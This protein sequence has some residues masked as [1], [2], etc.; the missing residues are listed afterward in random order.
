MPFREAFLAAIEKSNLKAADK[1]RLREVADDNEKFR[2]VQSAATAHAKLRGKAG[3][4]GAVDWSKIIDLIVQL[5][6]VILK[7]FGM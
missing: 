7:L 3:P 5:L 4:R 2:R 6:P 1:D